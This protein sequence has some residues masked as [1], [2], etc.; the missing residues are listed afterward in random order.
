MPKAT[1]R[2]RSTRR[3][4]PPLP[5]EPFVAA[6]LSAWRSDPISPAIIESEIGPDGEILKSP[7]FRKAKD[8]DWSGVFDVQFS[9]D[10]V[11]LKLSQEA[12][13]REVYTPRR[14]SRHIASLR[15]WEPLRIILNGKADWPSGRY[16]Y[17]QDYHVVL[18]NDLTPASFSPIRAF[19][20]QADLI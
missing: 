1:W 10:L 4:L 19:D 3:S 17:L 16:Y 2:L 13:R 6:G 18:C 12:C 9:G 5:I 20:L 11:K 14:S 15:F 7:V 8:R